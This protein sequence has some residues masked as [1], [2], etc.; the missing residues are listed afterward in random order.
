MSSI[1]G[2]GRLYALCLPLIGLV[3][4]GTGP[5]KMRKGK[6]TT[7][8]LVGIQFAGLVFQIACGDSS[9]TT[10]PRHSEGK[11]HDHRHC[12]ECDGLL[13]AFH[14]HDAHRAVGLKRNSPAPEHTRTNANSSP[15]FFRKCAPSVGRQQLDVGAPD[16]SVLSTRS[17]SWSS[18]RIRRLSRP[19]RKTA[20]CLDPHSLL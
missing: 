10:S 17:Q 13:K 1:A 11:V 15:R 16:R 5:G 4:C 7:A 18:P 2:S 9:T 3:V 19:L 20:G 8:A 14:S 6:L 12:H